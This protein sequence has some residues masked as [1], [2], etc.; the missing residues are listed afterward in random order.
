MSAQEAYNR[1][2]SLVAEDYASMVK[3]LDSLDPTKSNIKQPGGIKA[4]NGHPLS[5]MNVEIFIDSSGSMAGKVQGQTKM[6]LPSKPS[7]NLLPICRKE[8]MS[9]FVFTEIKERVARKIR[10]FLAV[11]VKCFTHFNRTIP[12]SFSLQSLI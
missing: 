7:N 8:P 9:Q 6:D 12:T 2:I 11:A 10:P 1:I 3:K 5:K 4:P